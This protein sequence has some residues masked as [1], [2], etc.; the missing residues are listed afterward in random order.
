MSLIAD[1]LRKSQRPSGFEPIKPTPTPPW[2]V[3]GAL[4]ALLGTVWALTWTPMRGMRS[5]SPSYR[6]SG[7]TA[8]D[9]RPIMTLLPAMPSTP[10]L[11]WRVDGVVTGMGTPP[12]AIINGK[13]VAEGDPVWGGAKVVSVNRNRVEILHNGELV[14]LPVRDRR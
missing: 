2:W 13:L 4:L 10:S 5:G 3:L 8:R 12:T 6:R 7:P 9:L 11:T 14:E 1:A